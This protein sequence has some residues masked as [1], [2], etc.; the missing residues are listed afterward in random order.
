MDL[1][2]DC[3][4]GLTFRKLEKGEVV[5]HYLASNC[6]ALD[7]SSPYE[8]AKFQDCHQDG[9][10]IKG[11]LTSPPAKFQVVSE[12]M[13]VIEAPVTGPSPKGQFPVMIVWN[14]WMYDM[15]LGRSPVRGPIARVR[16]P[17]A[18]A[19]TNAWCGRHRVSM[20]RGSKR[21]VRWA[22]RPRTLF[23]A[24]NWDVSLNP[25]IEEWLGSL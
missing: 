2:V 15:L 21:H 13:V 17:V 10:V 23:L 7:G 3:I 11:D 1:N 4:V 14:S 16:F 6:I 19:S 22:M 5:D 18:R 9:E 12:A 20:L 24:H 8:K 25:K